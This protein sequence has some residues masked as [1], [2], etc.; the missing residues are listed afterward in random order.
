VHPVAAAHQLDASAPGGAP[1]REAGLGQFSAI[2]GPPYS[3]LDDF[4]VWAG[5]H[6]KRW[7]GAP[8]PAP[9]EVPAD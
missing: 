4:G 9:A 8:E 2:H 5:R 3:Y 1:D 7:T 6:V